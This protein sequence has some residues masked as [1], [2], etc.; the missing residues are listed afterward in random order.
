MLGQNYYKK[1][2]NTGAAPLTMAQSWPWGSQKANLK[3]KLLK[4]DDFLNI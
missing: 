1:V 2:S 3:N 4:I